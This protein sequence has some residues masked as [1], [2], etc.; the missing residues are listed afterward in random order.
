MRGLAELLQNFRDKVNATLVSDE[1]KTEISDLCEGLR[2]KYSPNGKFDF[3]RAFLD[4]NVHYIEDEE[5][6]GCSAFGPIDNQHY[7]FVHPY[8]T[9]RLREYVKMHELAHIVLGHDNK[10]DTEYQ[11]HEAE[12]FARKIVGDYPLIWI[13]IQSIGAVFHLMLNHSGNFEEY[14][15]DKDAYTLKVIGK[16]VDL[17]KI[18]LPRKS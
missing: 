15:K 9:T 3:N 4:Y 8:G 5:F 10:L 18:P 17:N 11:E 7:I 16:Y 12:F 6:M 14:S 2:G 1:R 13:T